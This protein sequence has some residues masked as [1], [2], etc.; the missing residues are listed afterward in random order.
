MPGEESG[1]LGASLVWNQ[2]HRYLGMRHGRQDCLCAFAGVAA[3]DAAHIQAWPDAGALQG[4]V[5][6]FALNLF[7]IKEFLVFFK[8]EGSACKL[9]P[10]GLGELHYLVVETGHSHASVGIVK[11]CYHLAERGYGV[12]HGAAVMPGMQVLVGAGHLYFQITQAAHSAVDGRHLV[13]YH[14]G[15]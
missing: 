1:N 2:A 11:R 12:G 6:F 10:V 4:A 15:V 5:S 13:R 14:S 8:V 9:G 7:D 3:P